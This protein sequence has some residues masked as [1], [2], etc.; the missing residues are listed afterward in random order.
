MLPKNQKLNQKDRILL[1]PLTLSLGHQN[2]FQLSKAHIKAEK[3]DGN[4]FAS[5]INSP[6]AQTCC[7]FCAFVG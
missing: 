1:T 5:K 2:K 3:F 6:E 7:T 4:R